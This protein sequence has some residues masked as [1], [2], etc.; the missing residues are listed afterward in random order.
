MMYAEG[1]AVRLTA[2]SALAVFAYNSLT[3]QKVND[4]P[5]YARALLSLNISFRRPT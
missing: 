1:R 5:M 4:T 2:G 3:N